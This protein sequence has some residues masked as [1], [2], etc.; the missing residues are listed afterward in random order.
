MTIQRPSII[1]INMSSFFFLNS[2]HTNIASHCRVREESPVPSEM[3]DSQS[4]RSESSIL[5]GVDYETTK[6]K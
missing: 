4:R 5:D 6:A 3:G 1:M 2:K